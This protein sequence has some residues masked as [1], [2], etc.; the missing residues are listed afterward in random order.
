MKI[1]VSTQ[2]KAP[3]SLVWQLWNS[4]ESVTQWNFAS[5]DW[6]CPSAENDLKPGGTFKYRMAAKD[7]SFEFDFEGTYT[8]V[9]P[10]KRIVITLGDS[11]EMDVLFDE[12]EAGVTVTEIFDAEDL[13]SAELQKQGWQAILDNFKRHCMRQLA[14]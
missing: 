11:R 3:I 7:E 8:V 13:N 5:D 4:P 6:H 1:T 2:I 12:T 9:E 14:S 10:L